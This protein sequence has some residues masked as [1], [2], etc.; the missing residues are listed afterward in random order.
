MHTVLSATMGGGRGDTPILAFGIILSVVICF[1]L[2]VVWGGWPFTLVPD[3]LA[4][5]TCLIVASYVLA[6]LLLRTFDFSFLAGQAFYPGTD[7]SGPLPAWDGL[8]GGVTCL[9]VIFLFLHVDLWPMT[10]SP[11]LMR[12]P[13]LGA[14][15]SGLVLVVGVSGYLFG[16]RVLGMTPD[17]FLVTVPVPFMFGTVVLLT[18]LGGEL[19]RRIRGLVR[20]VVS[21]ALAMVFGTALARLY[22]LMQ[23]LLTPDV[24]TADGPLDLHLWL[25]SA[26]LAVTFPT[27]AMYHD[28][29]GFWPLV[30]THGSADTAALP[31]VEPAS[32]D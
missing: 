29:F 3:R 31:L 25:A 5:G 26:L 8:V 30:G 18:M 28:L 16:T 13:V 2:A 22:L 4:G 21:A 32:A 12:Q 1:W 11:R 7:P 15:W 23:P 17:A 27:M 20:G 9:A 19:T 24:P 10:R 14:T 6:G